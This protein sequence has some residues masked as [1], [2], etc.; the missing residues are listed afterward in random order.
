MVPCPADVVDP[1]NDQSASECQRRPVHR[2]NGWVAHSWKETHG[3]GESQE[4]K[5][6][7]IDGDPKL[8]QAECRGEQSLAAES[9][10]KQAED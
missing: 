2:F 8:A 4:G 9:A 10:K 3:K 6:A 5:A 7:N 1:T